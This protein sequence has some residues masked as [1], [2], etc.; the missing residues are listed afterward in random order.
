M[1]QRFISHRCFRGPRER[2]GARQRAD[3]PPN[4]HKQGDADPDNRDDAGH[5][6]ERPVPARKV[7]SRMGPQRKSSNREENPQLR[8]PDAPERDP[9]HAQAAG[10]EVD[11]SGQ[12][13]VRNQ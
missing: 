4:R 5:V 9:E 10:S 13:E 2:F 12:Q 7:H 6:E 8:R 1:S 11:F 3:V